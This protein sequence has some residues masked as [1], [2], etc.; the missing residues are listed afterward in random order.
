[1]IQPFERA[2]VFSHTVQLEW[3]VLIVG[4]RDFLNGR[5]SWPRL[6]VESGVFQCVPSVWPRGDKP[7]KVNMPQIG[8]PSGESRA[9]VRSASVP[10]AQLNPCFAS[11][12]DRIRVPVAAK[13]ALHTAGSSGG[14]DGSPNPVGELLL[15]RKCTSISVGT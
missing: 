10:Y 12:S 3:E 11:G 9:R 15:L 8:R 1:V 13:I 5:G 2:T 7:R 6:E 4:T 14:I